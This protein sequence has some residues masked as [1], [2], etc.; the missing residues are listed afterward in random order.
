MKLN[1]PLSIG[2][3][4]VE[5]ERGKVQ[6]PTSLNARNNPIRFHDHLRALE[7]ADFHVWEI[8][9]NYVGCPEKKEQLQF[10][11]ATLGKE[12]LHLDDM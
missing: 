5:Q 6:E 1:F 7:L 9:G 12:R 3:I 8:T 2:G 4:G 10:L 11:A